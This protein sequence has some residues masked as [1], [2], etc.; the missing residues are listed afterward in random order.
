MVWLKVFLLSSVK[1][2][3]DPVIS[4]TC[5]F[6]SFLKGDG[7][8]PKLLTAKIVAGRQAVS[9][10]QYPQHAIVVVVIV[11]VVVVVVV[12][13]LVVYVY[14]VVIWQTLS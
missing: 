9:V 2:L 4:L 1:F 14:V 3:F 11:I 6:K 8:G 7:V 13:V 12:I 5:M 10:A